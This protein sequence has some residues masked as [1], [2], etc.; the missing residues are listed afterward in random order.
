M[1][2]LLLILLLSFF[3]AER[4]FTQEWEQT[5][6]EIIETFSLEINDHRGVIFNTFDP[7]TCNSKHFENVHDAILDFFTSSVKSDLTNYCVDTL[8]DSIMEIPLSLH[9]LVKV[10]LSQKD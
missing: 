10:Y 8:D 6:L 4:A 7:L 9:D 1:M 3:V 2:K 5:E